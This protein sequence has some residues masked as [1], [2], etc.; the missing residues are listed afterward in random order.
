MLSQSAGVK[1]LP[2]SAKAHAGPT[3]AR[4]TCRE[5]ETS[6]P[7]ESSLCRTLSPAL[8][9][10]CQPGLWDSHAAR[11]EAGPRRL[12]GRGV[13]APSAPPPGPTLEPT[14]LGCPGSRRGDVGSSLL[15]ICRRSDN[16]QQ[17]PALTDQRA[18]KT[19]RRMRGV[20]GP[21]GWRGGPGVSRGRCVLPASAQALGRAGNAGKD[22][23]LQF[24]PGSSAVKNRPAV[25]EAQVRPLGQEDPLEKE[26]ATHFSILAWRIPWMEEPG[27]L[28]SMGSQR[29]GQD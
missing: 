11:R 21:R 19:P 27:G 2:A 3:P 18:E 28:Q 22:E 20:S 10:P 8:T 1:S 16:H 24:S 6:A 12:P 25:R 15:Q 7:V 29:V 23:A 13:Q 26:R 9:P 14:L 5:G 4:L 17:K